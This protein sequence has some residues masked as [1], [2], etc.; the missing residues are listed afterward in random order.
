MRHWQ[1]QR[2]RA[3]EAVGP[4]PGVLMFSFDMTSRQIGIRTA[5]RLSGL[6]PS[7]IRNGQL[8]D[9][10]CRALMRAEGEAMQLPIEIDD[11]EPYTLARVCSRIAQFCRIR[12]CALAIIDNLSKIVGEGKVDALFPA[13]LH[14]TSTLKKLVNRL[15]IPAMLLVH[16]PQTVAKRDN[17]MP[18]RG[19]L[20]YGIHMH[21][22]FAIGQWRPELALAQSPPE[23][24]R[25]KEEAHQE[26]VEKWHRR[27]EALRGVCELVPLKI[28]EDD[29]G[30]RPATLLFDTHTS[31]FTDPQDAAL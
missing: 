4:C 1:G 24:G 29:G 27:K 18:R 21:A 25:M 15:N 5:A 19:D 31:Q 13:F 10:V 30:G 16:L 3:G 26:L 9:Q 11:A 8:D 23:R 6:S 2:E 28:R 20:P 17:P 7:V 14:A 22:D 12:P